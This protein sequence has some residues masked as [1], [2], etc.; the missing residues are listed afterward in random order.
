MSDG[1]IGRDDEDQDSFNLLDGSWREAEH[2]AGRYKDAVISLHQPRANPG[3]RIRDA[4]IARVMASS[5][6]RLGR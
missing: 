2:E 1:R 3:R 6:R 5:R 4:Q